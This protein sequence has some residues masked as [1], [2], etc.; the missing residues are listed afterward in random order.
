MERV[1]AAEFLYWSVLLGHPPPKNPAIPRETAF[2]QKLGF[3]YLGRMWRALWT[4]ESVEL[5]V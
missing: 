3:A 4:K 1:P 5:N 2:P